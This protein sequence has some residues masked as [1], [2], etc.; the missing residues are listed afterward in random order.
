MNIEV[1]TK[2]L[3]SLG[4]IIGS[5]AVQIAQLQAI[6]SEYKAKEEQENGTETDEHTTTATE[7]A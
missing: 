6:V 4:F 2:A 1:Q 5:Q 3:Q 7:T